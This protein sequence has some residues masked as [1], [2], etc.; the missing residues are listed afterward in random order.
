MRASS[1]FKCDAREIF[2]DKAASKGSRD[3]V[4]EGCAVE[5][6]WIKAAT[7]F[8]LASTSATSCLLVHRQIRVSKRG[9]RLHLR[10]VFQNLGKPLVAGILDALGMESVLLGILLLLTL[11]V[12]SRGIV[13][14]SWGW[15]RSRLTGWGA[16]TIDLLVARFGWGR[17]RQAG[18]HRLRNT[19]GI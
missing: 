6:A 9:C 16:S 19:I 1:S 12:A 13:G 15:R 4:V 7:K 17:W 8:G 14:V 3:A 5:G 11:A 10:F 2:S 18:V